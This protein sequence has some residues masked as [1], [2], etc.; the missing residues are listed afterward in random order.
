[1]D[2]RVAIQSLTQ[3]MATHVLRDN[4]V[5]FNPNIRTTASGIRNFT[6]M[7]PPTFFGSKVE[8]DPQRFVDKVFKVNDSMGINSQEKVELTAYPL[9]DVTLVFNE[10]WKD[11]RPVRE[12]Q[13]T[14]G[15]FK[16]VFL[17]RF[18]PFELRERKM[19]ELINLRQG[20]ISVKEYSLKFT[21]LS[22]YVILWLWILELR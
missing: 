5:Q 10:Q 18:F 20:G 4:R 17:D 1:M 7:N 12:G 6:R 11:E 21:Q 13:I 9:K 15:E 22:K 14:W 16:M 3:V 2:I 8:E 19:Q